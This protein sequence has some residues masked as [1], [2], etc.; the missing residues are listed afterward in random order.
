MCGSVRVCGES[1][2]KGLVGNSTCPEAGRSQEYL[3]RG[4]PILGFFPGAGVTY[5]EVCGA[6]EVV[7]GGG[8]R[9]G[10]LEYTVFPQPFPFA[11]AACTRESEHTTTACRTC[12]PREALARLSLKWRVG[13]YVL[14]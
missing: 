13:A 12:P 8:I 7:S 10:V 6:E 5:W 4:G 2:R 3:S 1:L 11:R 14:P 9:R